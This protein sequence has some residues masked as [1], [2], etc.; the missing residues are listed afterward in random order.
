MKNQSI[1]V[2]SVISIGIGV[3]LGSV[4]GSERTD[5]VSDSK[6]TSTNSPMNMQGM[7]MMPDGSMMRN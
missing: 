7:H 4:W 5:V 6:E 1:I 2:I 3:A